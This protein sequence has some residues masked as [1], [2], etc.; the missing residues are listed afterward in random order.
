VD[1]IGGSSSA[2][3]DVGSVGVE[4]LQSVALR[5]RANLRGYWSG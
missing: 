1:A 4:D 2:T 3:G 5:A